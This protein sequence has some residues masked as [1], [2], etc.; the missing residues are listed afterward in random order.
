[1]RCAGFLQNKQHHR[2]R[3]TQLYP[4]LPLLKPGVLIPRLFFTGMPNALT[5]EIADIFIRI[6]AQAHGGRLKLPP[7]YTPFAAT[8]KADIRLRLHQTKPRLPETEKVFVSS[9]IWTLH[10]HRRLSIIKIFEELEVPGS[11]LV[12]DDALKSVDLYPAD[13][14]GRLPDPFD[15]PVLELLMIHC[16]A[17]Q[18]GVILHS[19]GIETHGRGL[20]FVG[21]SGAGKSTLTR[22]WNAEPRIEILSDD[23]TI[24]RR[25]GD[26]YR[27]YGTPWHGEAKFGLP[28]S[29][30]LDKIFFIHHA[31][32]N[33][34]RR[35]NRAQAVQYL[36]T[37]VFA[38]FWEA[39]GMQFSMNFLSR[40]AGRV[41]CCKLGFLPDESVIRDINNSEV[42]MN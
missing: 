37:C 9:P 19:C 13:E 16:L 31:D 38:P 24:V 36:L 35:I 28:Q 34:Q 29:A 25:K 41:P 6:E 2:P 10:R 20:L 26:S 3:L 14:S 11:T 22:L 7:A 1:M 15:G 8:G 5:I 18:R 32:T 42:G 39:K 40:L 33:R 27:I 17:R 30:R 4:G 23:R 12:F 21:E